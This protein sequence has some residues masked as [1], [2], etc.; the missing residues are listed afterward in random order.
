M[1]LIATT[2]PR[3]DTVRASARDQEGKTSLEWHGSA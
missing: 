3:G 1:K 2:R